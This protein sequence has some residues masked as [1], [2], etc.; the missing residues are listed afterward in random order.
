MNGTTSKLMVYIQVFVL[1][2]CKYQIVKFSYV[3]I[4]KFTIWL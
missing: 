3:Y 2:A 1:S 4:V